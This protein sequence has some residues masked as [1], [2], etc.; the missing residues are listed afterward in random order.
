MKNLIIGKNSK[1]VREISSELKNYDFISH[2]D[3]SA[4]DF[5]NYQK[6]IIFSWSNRSLVENINLLKDIS[7]EKI[8]FIST[9]AVFSLQKRKQWNNYP[10]WKSKIEERVLNNDGAVL[11][12]GIWE[13][14]FR[15][16]IYGYFPLTSKKDLVK[17]LNEIEKIEK[18]TNCFQ[19]IEGKLPLLL[20]FYAKTINFISTL[21]PN[22]FIFRAPLELLIKF[23]G[24]KSYGFSEDA[25]S[26]FFK[27]VMIGGGCLG[28]EYLKK[29]IVDRVFVSNKKDIHLSEYGFK[30]TIVGLKN[31]GLAKYWHGVSTS[32]VKDGFI[33]KKTPLFVDRSRN[34]NKKHL[35]HVIKIIE[36]DSFIEV[37]AEDKNDFRKKY[38][39]SN[40]V[41]AAG[42]FSNSMLLKKYLNKD[43]YFDDHESINIGSV[44]LNEAC[45]K[46]Y[47]SK[48]G[49]LIFSNKLSKLIFRNYEMLVESRPHNPSKFHTN[50]YADTT[51]NIFLKLLKRFDFYSINEAFFNKFGFAFCTDRA[52][53]SLQILV[54][55]AIKFDGEK[56]VRTRISAEEFQGIANLLKSRFK[57]FQPY[58][59]ESF[60]GQHIMGG[61]E[62]FLND[63]LLKLIDSDKIKILG[64]PT[65]ERLEIFHHT[66]SL[67]AKI[68]NETS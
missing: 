37:I 43:A 59:F 5:N 39:S 64:S 31:N 12:I 54:K 44:N 9:S 18:E 3:I 60:D 40:L 53:I 56:F 6:V 4:T 35:S 10:N 61:K 45:E 1:I 22:N 11:R 30:D 13:Q 47:L 19:I 36:R 7:P 28:G 26:F 23:L 25:N 58:N 41:L 51:R 49:P 62:F 8:I 50:L 32:E 57:N 24:I 33:K 2:K 55:K 14:K 15:N 17:N 38:F 48:K 34:I 21:L 29:N 66:D 20:T 42:A 52:S 27:K 63:E 68:R 65:E 16:S 46:D 67:K